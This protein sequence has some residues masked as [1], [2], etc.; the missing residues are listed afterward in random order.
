M[1]G[2]IEK[3]SD[4]DYRVILAELESAFLFLDHYM[5]EHFREEESL[6]AHAGPPGLERHKIAHQ[7]FTLVM[8]DLREELLN[9]RHV[10][11]FGRKLVGKLME[12]LAMHIME[13]DQEDLKYVVT[14]GRQATSGGTV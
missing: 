4:L 3:L 6:M 12:W 10:A 11:L 2:I 8:A 13:H 5:A 14:R 9:S 7:E 1:I